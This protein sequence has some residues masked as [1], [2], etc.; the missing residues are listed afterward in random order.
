FFNALRL[1]DG[2][3]IRHRFEAGGEGWLAVC[4]LQQG[5]TWKEIK[6]RLAAKASEIPIEK[7]YSLNADSR[8]LLKWILDLRRD[9]F[10]MGMT[11]SVAEHLEMAMGIEG[12]GG[13][14]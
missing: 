3:E 7:R 9:E 10:M 1:M 6:A 13:E 14:V 5:V 11:P 8:A 4:Q 2:I 12:D